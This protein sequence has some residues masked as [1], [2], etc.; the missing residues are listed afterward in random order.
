MFGAGQS[1]QEREIVQNLAAG[2]TIKT[3]DALSRGNAQ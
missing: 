2:C 1:D 3:Q